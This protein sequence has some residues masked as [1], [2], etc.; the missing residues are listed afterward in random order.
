MGQDA[1]S[2]GGLIGKGFDWLFGGGGNSG[3]GNIGDPF[4]DNFGGN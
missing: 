1:P 3:Y 2:G 4:A